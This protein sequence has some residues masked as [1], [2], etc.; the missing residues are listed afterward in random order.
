MSRIKRARA[1]LSYANVAATLA[2]FL[3]LGGGAAIAANQITARDIAK[4]AVGGSELKRD[5][6]KGKHVKED[7]LGP[8][9]SAGKANN[10]LWAVV[11]NPNGQANV[12]VIRAGQDG[13]GVFETGNM[14]EVEFSREVTNCVWIA[15]R[16]TPGQGNEP[17]GFV[18]TAL[19][20]TASRVEVRARNTN[21]ELV[22]GD[23]HIIVV[24]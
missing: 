19:G 24:C 7:T 11:Q 1:R 9:P 4:D 3:A 14:V 21:G 10:L 13:T 23:F 15:S 17:A 16:G 22:E 6:A 5:A 2:L 8:V 12:N 18:Q 20:S